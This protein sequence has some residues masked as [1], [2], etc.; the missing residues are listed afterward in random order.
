VKQPVLAQVRPAAS[1]GSVAELPA[2][3]ATLGKETVG[4]PGQTEAVHMTTGSI[5]FVDTSRTWRSLL[6]T[7]VADSTSAGCPPTRHHAAG[8]WRYG[9]PSE[10]SAGKKRIRE[11]TALERQPW[12][13]DQVVDR[14][15]QPV[16]DRVGAYFP[17]GSSTAQ[18]AAIDYFVNERMMLFVSKN[19]QRDGRRFARVLYGSSNRSGLVQL[20]GTVLAPRPNGRV[21]RRR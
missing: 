7:V 8:S 6:N 16:L 3:N 17:H 1:P 13:V 12:P 9:P 4:S 2:Q 19:H 15:P 18:L 11:L 14:Q 21:E 5:V 20:E 10:P